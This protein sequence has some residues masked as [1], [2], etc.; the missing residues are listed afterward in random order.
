MKS[1]SLIDRIAIKA[2][3]SVE[4]IDALDGVRGLAVF[5][6]IASHTNGLHLRGQGAIGVWLF[7]VLSGF[8]LAL[9]FARKPEEILSLS[10]MGRF[11]FK[12][13][14]RVLPMYYISIG[15][16]YLLYPGF[17]ESREAL[18]EHALLLKA[19]GHLWSVQQEMVFYFIMPP[20]LLAAYLFM[21]VWAGRRLTF[22]VVLVA[23][24]LAL[25]SYL[26]PSIFHLHGS[27]LEL[28]LYIGIFLVGMA[29]A[30]FYSS[31]L[32][33]RF[34]R[35][36]W[37]RRA[38]N[39]AAIGIMAIYFLS[40]RFYKDALGI[41]TDVD[42]VGWSYPM[43]FGVT[44]MILILSLLADVRS[45]LAMILSSRYVRSVGI[46]SYSMYLV[47][48]IVVHYMSRRV[49]EGNLLFVY[50]FAAS[51]IISLFTYLIIEKPCI[52]YHFEV[53]SCSPLS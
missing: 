21:K 15:M 23:L 48:Y 3:S 47:H 11:M 49:P 31:P 24:G 7:F 1:I 19:N 35:L 40:A 38:S 30:Y 44:A 9:P 50:V 51:Y 16:Y 37:A 26:T 28:P 45:R 32:Y 10:R 4:N 41:M 34:A 25:N 20:V 29:S 33:E 12:R 42:H 27:S 53:V 13:L 14:K 17:I 52:E 46:V 43:F 36:R 8:L 39:M 5:L 2:P 18:A 22:G 6:V